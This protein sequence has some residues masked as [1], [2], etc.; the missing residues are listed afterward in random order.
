[1]AEEKMAE[2][3]SWIYTHPAEHP[4]NNPPVTTV[5]VPSDE[6][7]ED[8]ERSINAALL[9][10]Q[11]K[12]DT[13]DVL[14]PLKKTKTEPVDYEGHTVD[15]LKEMAKERGL[16]VAWDTRKAELVKALEKQDK[17]TT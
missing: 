15:E 2:D 5:A 1:M 11:P 8:Y 13:E 10:A 7:K 17:T 6:A 9:K 4:D 12:P 14:K 3:K 16:D